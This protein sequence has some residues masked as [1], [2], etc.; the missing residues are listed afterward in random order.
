MKPPIFSY[1]APESIEECTALLGEYGDEAKII[2]GGQSLM[3]LLSLR[4]LRPKVVIDIARIKGLERIERAAG[5]LR[6]GAMVLQRSVERAAQIAR[7]TPLLA[8]AVP[9]IGHVATRSRGTIVGSMCHADPAAELPVC[10]TLL[11]AQFILQSR[12]GSR[13]LP[14]AAFFSNAMVTA[15][16]ADELV[17]AVEF[18]ESGADTGFAFCELARRNGD[19]ALLSVAARI[20]RDPNGRL[21]DGAVA[22][23]GAGDVPRRFR[24]IDF[25][26]ENSIDPTAIAAFGDH[27]SDAIDARTD[28]HASADY[29]R[30]IAK[31]LV[32]RAL[33]AA[34]ERA[35][36]RSQP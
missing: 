34:V 12:T 36:P 23:G 32:R 22:L 13:T 8:Y 2:A 5:G 26:A 10:A 14:A 6:I 24:M 9:H 3:P 27:V 21:A 20:R 35:A 25:L 18:P 29:R 17:V 15:T 1:A 7:S 4:M 19:F 28:L 11:D 33:N 31:E 30:A 16:R